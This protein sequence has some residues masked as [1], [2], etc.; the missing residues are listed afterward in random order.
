MSLPTLILI[1]GVCFGVVGAAGFTDPPQ[2]GAY[3]AFA[4]GIGCCIAGGL[5]LRR[6]AAATGNGESHLAAAAGELSQRLE[7]IAGQVRDLESRMQQLPREGF[8]AEIDEILQ[9]EYFELTRRNEQ[10]TAQLGFS[11]Y[12][13]VWTGV[14]VGERLL[15]RAWSIATDGHY[16]EAKTEIPQVRAQLQSALQ[17]AEAIA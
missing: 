6:A 11:H 2:D 5:M 4:V 8:C 3:L 14:A 7:A 13:Q 12:S 9:G 10:Y 15:A 1:L 16:D 17:Q